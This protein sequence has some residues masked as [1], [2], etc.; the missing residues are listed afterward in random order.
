MHECFTISCVKTYHLLNSTLH[1][2]ANA[3]Y[4]HFVLDF[5]AR[6]YGKKPKAFAYRFYKPFTQQCVVISTHGYSSDIFYE[7]VSKVF[8]NSNSVECQF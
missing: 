6:A 5:M 8:C 3:C 4:R 2:K 1:S 7:L